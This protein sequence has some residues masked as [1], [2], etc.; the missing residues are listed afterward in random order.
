MTL[1]QRIRHHLQQ[2]RYDR[3]EVLRLTAERNEAA[4]DYEAARARNDTRGQ[5]EASK[6]ARMALHKLM[7]A[8]G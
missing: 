4:A 8:G 7:A 2:R 3:D 5:N 1:I 6:R